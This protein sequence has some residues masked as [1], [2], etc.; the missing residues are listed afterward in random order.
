MVDVTNDKVYFCFGGGT[1]S[2]P[3]TLDGG[4][5]NTFTVPSGTSLFVQGQ[6]YVDPVASGES[7]YM[8]GVL[9][10]SAADSNVIIGK[11]LDGSTFTDARWNVAISERAGTQLTTGDFNILIGALSGDKIT[12][13]KENV[14]IGIQTLDVLTT[15]DGLNM[16]IGS[17]SM[18]SLISGRYNVGMGPRSGNG[19]NG[20]SEGNVNV[21]Y[22]AGGG[23]GER[24]GNVNI[25]N[26]VNRYGTGE[27]ELFIDNSSTDAPLIYGDFATDSLRF[28]SGTTDVSGA[29]VFAVAEANSGG[30]AFAVG[31]DDG[32]V[33]F[34]IKGDGTASIL[35]GNTF[36]FDRANEYGIWINPE[37]GNKAYIKDSTSSRQL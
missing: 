13:S 25:G 28:G 4:V 23:I 36:F 2:D 3:T 7:P 21:G 16:A 29:S 27:N 37:D 34:Q 5:S 9:D 18:G 14:G 11:D 17:H 33:P 32:T 20:A 12:S 19:L 8:R 22:Y 15:G 26:E 1:W 10:L 31:L 24:D 6:L 35:S 30:T